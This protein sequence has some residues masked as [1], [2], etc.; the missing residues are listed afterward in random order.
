MISHLKILNLIISENPFC[1]IREHIR[2]LWGLECRYLGVHFLL[3]ATPILLCNPDQTI[4]LSEPASPCVLWRIELINAFQL[5][6]SMI[7]WPKA[8]QHTL[9]EKEAQVKRHLS[10]CGGDTPGGATQRGVETRAY[11]PQRVSLPRL[12]QCVT[13]YSEETQSNIWNIFRELY[14]LLFYSSLLE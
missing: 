4:H 7:L 5:W 14:F 8:H 11:R 9:G 3:I 13:F 10:G 2:R 1:H 12:T 6:D